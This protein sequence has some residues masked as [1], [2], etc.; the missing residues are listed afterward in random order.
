MKIKL[1]AAAAATVMAGSVMAQSAFEGLY[2]Q[3]GIGYE[4]NKP[5][6]SF[7]GSDTPG[8]PSIS[9]GN[10][11]GFSGAIGLGYT[12][13][14]AKNFLITLGA[15][16]SPLSNTA[17]IN[18]NAG[19]G[20]INNQYKF[21]NRTNLFIA[22]GFL[23]YKDRQV[24]VKAGYSMLN[25]K[26]SGEMASPGGNPSANLNGYVIGLGYKQLINKNVFLFGEGNYYSY[27][28][29]S[30]NYNFGED[31]FD[32]T[33]VKANSMNLLVGVGYKF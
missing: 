25:L 27:G 2:G 8:T 16:Y 32:N 14:V 15:D 17:N 7:V 21:S 5:K 20:S 31:S 18:I 1:L 19:D 33:N 13:S 12:A 10:A 4:S 11:N 3:I 9:D 24:Y 26:T 23:I 28:N 30:I 6:T 29:R 22:P